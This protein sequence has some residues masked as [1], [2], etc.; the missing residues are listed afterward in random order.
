[1]TAGRSLPLA[2]LDS[3]ARFHEEFFLP[4]KPVVVTGAARSMPAWRR[5]TDDYLRE[6][7]GDIHQL[8]TLSD[9]RRALMFIK[10][11][12]PY[13][14]NP[15]AFASATGPIYMT[16]LYLRPRFHGPALDQL[17]ADVECP[18][19]FGGVFPESRTVYLGPRGTATPMHQDH[20]NMR[21]WMAQ[22]RGDKEWRICPPDAF[23]ADSFGLVDAFQRTDLECDVY[24]AT[25]ASG[26][27]LYLPPRWWHQARNLNS[28]IAVYGHFLPLEEA[29][30]SLALALASDEVVKRT[31]SE[32]WSAVLA[33]LPKSVAPS[34]SLASA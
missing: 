20:F 15:G 32:V 19:S 23:P 7:V 11:Y 5:W 10:D 21:A 8:V 13:L 22:I 18:L 31:W 30:S 9:E 29:Q 3:P 28:T 33:L 17:A 34:L 27:V 6:T 12:L 26:D 14:A 4:G 25:V 2:R 1:M 24:H 16:D